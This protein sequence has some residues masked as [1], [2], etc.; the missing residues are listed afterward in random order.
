MNI[1]VLCTYGSV[2]QMHFYKYYA[3]LLLKMSPIRAKHPD[4]LNVDDC[5]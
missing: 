3:A 2:F 4:Y 1:T 5:G